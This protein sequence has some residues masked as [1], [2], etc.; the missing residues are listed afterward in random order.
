MHKRESLKTSRSERMST[1]T[2]RPSCI[3]ILFFFKIQRTLY[4]ECMFN[5]NIY[6]I[7]TLYSTFSWYTHIFF[8]PSLM[9]P[10][11]LWMASSSSSLLTS[12]VTNFHFFQRDTCHH[13]RNGIFLQSSFTLFSWVLFF[14]TCSMA[15]FR[16]FLF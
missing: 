16:K 12:Y 15:L 14:F 8:S 10:Y 9:N 3:T 7:S 13:F 1:K 5:K 4:D 2:K 11:F 6:F